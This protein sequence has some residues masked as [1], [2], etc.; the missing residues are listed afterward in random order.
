MSFEYEDYVYRDDR[1]YVINL[2]RG[3]VSKAG[4][5]ETQY[6]LITYRN[7]LSLPAVR[8]DPFETEEEAINY[9][10]EVE[11]TVPLV[12]NNGEPLEIP[13]DVDQWEYWSAWLEERGLRSATTGYQ[14]LP[15][16]IREMGGN[17][18][19]DY[20]KVEVL[21]DLDALDYLS[22]VDELD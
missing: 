16:H 21:S 7:T 6:L 12:S 11:F 13:E 9:L 14:N 1:M 2:T 22:D 20:V 15:D 3:S 19:N 17:P 18:R 10:K 5:T 8:T 4:K